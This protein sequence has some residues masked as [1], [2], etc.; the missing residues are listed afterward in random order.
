MAAIKIKIEPLISVD[1][2]KEILGVKRAFVYQAIKTLGLPYYRIN[3][4]NI[5]FK[6]SEVK[7][8]IQERRKVA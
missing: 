8:W 3:S 6:N 7:Q 2:V 1:E 5:K 4:R